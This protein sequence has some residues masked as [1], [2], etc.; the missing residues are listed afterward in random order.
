M[1]ETNQT[2]Y[3]EAFG[4]FAPALT[5]EELDSRIAKILEERFEKNNTREVKK[6]LHSTIDLTTLS[7]T[8]TEEKVARLVASVND[9]EGTEDVP[10]VA[11]IC[12]YPNFVKTVREVLTA[13]GVQVACVSGCFPASQSFPEVEDR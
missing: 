6:F 1:A 5:V 11:A 9:F 4:A 13:E 12:V 2:K 8:D 10:S 3:T 7:G